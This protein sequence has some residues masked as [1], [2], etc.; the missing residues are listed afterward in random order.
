[1]SSSGVQAFRPLRS[2]LLGQST[3]H[4]E[5]PVHRGDQVHVDDEFELLDR[6]NARLAGDLV[7]AHGQIVARDARG[8]HAQRH[9]A[10]LG[11]DRVENRATK[12][13]VGHVAPE[14]DRERA[15]DFGV[16]LRGNV[17][18]R[19]ARVDQCHS[20]GATLAHRRGH[21]TPDATRTACHDRDSVGKVHLRP[22]NE[23]CDAAF[24]LFRGIAG[25]ANRQ[26]PRALLI[27]VRGPACGAREHARRIHPMP[28][29]Y[30]DHDPA[31]RVAPA[32]LGR[33]TMRMERH[34]GWRLRTTGF[35]AGR[36][37]AR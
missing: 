12:P 26:R 33:Y 14:R 31:D 11:A 16:D 10:E 21:C 1:M 8:R 32:R 18:D 17:L 13:I 24:Y 36:R 20:V 2:A 23:C 29:G 22:L 15:P 6:I 19:L 28:A 34:R 5:R 3:D 27:C 37:G 35:V 9:L 25:D 30:P 4:F 7:H